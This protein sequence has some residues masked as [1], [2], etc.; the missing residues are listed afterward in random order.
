MQGIL[1]FGG[2]GHGKVVADIARAAG[3]AMSGVVDDD[4]SKEGQ[5]FCGVPI[6]S[7]AR[8]LRQR[9]S[10]KHHACVLGVGDNEARRRTMRRLLAHGFR[11]VSIVHP[12]AVVAPS[13]TV[14]LGTV[15]MATAVVN[16][17]AIV[18]DGVILN[19]GAIVE[20]DC[21]VGPFA[22]LSPNVALGGGVRIGALSHLGLGAV[23]LPGVT[24]GDSVIVGAGA[25]VHRDVK[26][27][28]TVAGVP[29]RPLAAR[30]GRDRSRRGAPVRAETS[31]DEIDQPGTP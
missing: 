2:G 19:T 24:V 17:D 29:A 16:P 14:G 22:H 30:R 1:V 23:V 3:H 12:S 31:S 15:V 25:V 10:F 26:S 21:R 7:W 13:A 6:V 8:L 18:G 5:L 27:G 4:E 20:H 28:S 11:V 9:E